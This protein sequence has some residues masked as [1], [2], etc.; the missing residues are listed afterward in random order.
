MEHEK[1][2]N[3]F[4]KEL[5]EEIRNKIADIDSDPSGGRRIYFENAGGSLTLKSCCSIASSLSAIPDFPNRPTPGAKPLQKAI[6]DGLSDCKLIFGTKTGAILAELTVSK[7]IFTI[8]GVIM[9]SV[10]G[11]NVVTTELDHPATYDACHYY[12]EIFNKEVRTA[13]IDRI[14]GSVDIE[15]LLGK[16]DR[17]TQLLSFIHSSNITG[18]VNNVKFI[19]QEA[20]KINPDIYVLLDSTQHVPHGTIDVEDLQV[21]AACFAPYKIL[22]KRGL[23]IGWVSD[24][25]VELPH[26]RF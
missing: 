6:D 1:F 15:D 10:P 11:S 8:T 2:R 7:A 17:N 25:V 14:T 26:P 20:R 5:V 4:S 18:T 16:I 13:K 21:D 3:C 24:R 23:G 19:V 9:R 22:G 12:G